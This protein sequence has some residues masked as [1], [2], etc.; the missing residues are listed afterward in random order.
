MHKQSLGAMMSQAGF[1]RRLVILT[2][3]I[4]FAGGSVRTWAASQVAQIKIDGNL[5]LT[6]PIAAFCGQYPNAFAM[7]IADAC[8]QN[9]IPAD[10]FHIDFQD[11]GGKPAQAVSVVHKQVLSSAP[12]LYIS[13]TSPVSL[14]IAHDINELG[15]PHMLVSFDA[16]ICHDGPNRLRILTSHKIEA[17]RYIKEA[18]RLKAKKVL[19]IALNIVSYN[20]E[21]GKI[22]EPA[23]KQAGIE[24]ARESFSFDTKDFRTIALKTAQYKPDLILV[25]G[26]SVHVYPILRALREYQLIK[27]D[28]VLCSLDFIDLLHNRTPI[29]ELEGIPFI[30]PPFEISNSPEKKEWIRRFESTYHKDPSYVEAYAYDAGRIVVAAYRKF[31]KVDAQSI[32]KVLPFHGICGEVDIDQDGDLNTKL[33]IA[34]VMPDGTVKA[35]K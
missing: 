25:A 1:G 14:A 28:N 21:F 32:R 26:H 13:G 8:K 2:G 15:I 17:P 12:T 3:L 33:L 6:G 35:I 34:Q 27:K 31:G 4:L 22:V 29:S 18:K 19:I 20:N 16:F 5:P 7:G 10:R 11:N 23:F 30:A 24:F 9:A